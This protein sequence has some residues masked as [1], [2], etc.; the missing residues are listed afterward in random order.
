LEQLELKASL[1]TEKGKGAA[2]RLR[3]EGFI[4][5]YFMVRGPSLSP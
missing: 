5:G 1:R 2:K 4:P 3:R